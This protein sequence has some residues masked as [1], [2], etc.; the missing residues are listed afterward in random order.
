M[1]RLLEFDL[2]VGSTERFVAGLQ[3][4]VEFEW[5]GPEEGD[6]GWS[7]PKERLGMFA[8]F[9]NGMRPRAG[10][11]GARGFR[12]ALKGGWREGP[13]VQGADT[14]AAAAGPPP[15]RTAAAP[16]ASS[17]PGLTFSLR[18]AAKPRFGLAAL[19]NRPRI[20]LEPPPEPISDAGD[21][22]MLPAAAAPV[23]PE[24]GAAEG[25]ELPDA[26]ASASDGSSS[27]SEAEDGDGGGEDD[28]EGGAGFTDE[29]ESLL[30]EAE[31]EALRA[32]AE[33]ELEVR[34]GVT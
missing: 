16:S 32:R 29:L 31:E 6:E 26:S 23:E 28:G 7:E 15:A 20:D 5:L 10:E 3:A 22:G 9:W 25:P 33:M 1:L 4:L 19:A 17:A 30:R 18:P 24:T 13:A 21:A 14:G 11:P 12:D 34:K 27:G 8:E 2:G